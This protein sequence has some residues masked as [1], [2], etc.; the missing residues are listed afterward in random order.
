MSAE[1]RIRV[2]PG[3]EDTSLHYFSLPSGSGWVAY[4]VTTAILLWR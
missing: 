1:Q 3:H 2:V 4:Q